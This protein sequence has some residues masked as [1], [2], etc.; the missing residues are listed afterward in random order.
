MQGQRP[1]PGP[2]QASQFPSALRSRE[3]GR[4]QEGRG[5]LAGVG[6]CGVRE[7]AVP[8]TQKRRAEQQEPMQELRHVLQKS[9][10]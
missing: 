4:L 8:M 7:A 1:G 2:G 6:S 10:A 3:V 5:Q 9:W